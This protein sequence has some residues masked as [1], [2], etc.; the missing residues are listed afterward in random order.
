MAHP[1]GLR[2]RKQ[3]T[4]DTYHYTELKTGKIPTFMEETYVLLHNP[5]VIIHFKI[6]PESLTFTVRL[7]SVDPRSI[8]VA[9]D[10]TRSMKT[11]PFVTR[12]VTDGAN[13]RHFSVRA[14]AVGVVSV[15]CVGQ[16]L[17][18]IN[19][20]RRNLRR[21]FCKKTGK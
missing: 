17:T 15:L 12:Q 13:V 10:V 14:P 18:R 2:K 7:L 11:V 4:S 3:P 20:G 6:I 5:I 21:N 9:L 8:A 1:Y 16:G 19:C